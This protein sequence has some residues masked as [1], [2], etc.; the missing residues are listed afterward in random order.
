MAKFF[1]RPLPQNLLNHIPMHVGE[2]HVAAA[3]VV[4]EAFVVEA[5]QVQNRGVQIVDGLAV[6]DGAVA[7]VVGGADDGAAFDARARQP[8]REA[9]GVVVAAVEPL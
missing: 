3:V 1:L 5:H 8:E 9:V 2:A 7:E 6:F 4:G